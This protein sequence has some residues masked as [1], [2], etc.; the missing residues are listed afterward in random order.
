MAKPNLTPDPGLSYGDGRDA[1]LRAAVVVVARSGL[2][3]LTYRAV[4]DEAG[5]AHALVRH[6]F[7]SRDALIVAATEYS[8]AVAIETGGLTSD[9][10]D[11]ADFAAG[12]GAVLVEAADLTAFQ[13]E[14]I[15]ESRRRPELRPAVAGLYAGFRSAALEDLRQRG[16]D[17]DEALGV[18]VFAAL[19]GL[20]FQGLALDEPEVTEAALAALRRLL[21][22]DAAA[23]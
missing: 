10:T 17:A 3:G 19:D 18:L 13:F 23:R 8:L 11:L 20:V 22:L 9:S 14:V 12:T 15:L 5:V 1:L 6:H 16:V 4:A 7:D 2:R 21:A